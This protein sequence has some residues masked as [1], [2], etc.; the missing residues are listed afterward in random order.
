MCLDRRHRLVKNNDIFAAK[1]KQDPSRLGSFHAAFP[2]HNK[3]K[4]Q[5]IRIMSA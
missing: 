2:N 3:L 5:V 4:G 1:S